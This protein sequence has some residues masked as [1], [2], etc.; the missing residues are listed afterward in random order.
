MD[1]R[2]QLLIKWA[3]GIVIALVVMVHWT[4]HQTQSNLQGI[5]ASASRA[6]WTDNFFQFLANIFGTGA[7]GSLFG[8]A[9]KVNNGSNQNNPNSLQMG[10][11]NT[12]TNS[13]DMQGSG[14]AQ[15]NKNNRNNSGFDRGNNFESNLDDN[16]RDASDTNAATNAGQETGN[17]SI[18]NAD[19]GSKSLS[20]NNSEDASGDN[21]ESNSDNNSDI[22]AGTN[23]DQGTGNNSG[24]NSDANATTNTDQGTGN[25]SGNNSG[26][27]S[28]NNSGGG[29][30][31]GSGDN[32]GNNSGDNSG[33]NSGSNTGNNNQPNLPMINP[34]P[35]DNTVAQS[36]AQ[37][38]QQNDAQA[39]LIQSRQELV[40]PVQQQA[41]AAKYQPVDPQNITQPSTD[42]PPADVQEKAMSH[43]LTLH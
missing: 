39:A 14:L 4:T 21:S 41:Q 42:Q 7:P 23:A 11:M 8:Q 18:E 3:I 16:L 24:D 40:A 9:S 22:N 27:N 28:G 29:S 36:I 10:G 35:S 13:S 32:S 2:N 15:Q 37:Q 33:N 5:S 26:D 20:E 1:K 38:N 6:S 43:Q 12:A 25:N 34:I 31:N 19:D 17:L 30:G